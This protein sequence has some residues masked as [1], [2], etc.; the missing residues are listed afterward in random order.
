L[1]H[2]DLFEK[3]HQYQSELSLTD[4]ILVVAISNLKLK[5]D[6]KKI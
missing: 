3:F 5:I 4:K 2:L 1:V 6:M